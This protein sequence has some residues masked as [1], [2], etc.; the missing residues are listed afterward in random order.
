MSKGK[1]LYRAAVVTLGAAGI[2]MA[3]AGEARAGLVDCPAAFILDGTAKVHDG[4]ALPTVETAADDCQYIVPADNNNVASAANVNAAGFFGFT[5]WAGNGGSVQVDA[6]AAAGTWAIAG[7]NFALYDYMITFKDGQDTNLISFLL[8]ESYSSGGWSTPFT[9]PPFDFNGG[10]VSHNVSHYSIFQ[11]LADDD[12]VVVP[13][14]A[15]LLM[16][17]LGLAAAAT[18][19]RRRTA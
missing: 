10:S 1:G 5:D 6:S 14:P 13:E 16:L 15:T 7:V 4:G 19:M 11:R 8:N 3:S 12:D 17:G 2:V 9:E 18:R